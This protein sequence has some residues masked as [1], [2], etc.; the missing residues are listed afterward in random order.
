[1]SWL[2]SFSLALLAMLTL[3]VAMERHHRQVRGV[4]PAPRTR[5]LLRATGGLLMPASLWQAT[6]AFGI[7]AG[8]VVW[9]A[10][11]CAAGV[12]VTW[13]LPYRPRAAPLLALLGMPGAASGLID[14]MGLLTRSP[15]V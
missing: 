4:P 13:L 9:C 1:M 7:G 14:L 5:L 12:V 15:A 2:A 6:H 3:S 8:L 11:L 10:M